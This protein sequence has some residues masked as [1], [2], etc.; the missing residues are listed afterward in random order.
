MKIDNRIEGQTGSP[1][2]LTISGGVVLAGVVFHSISPYWLFLA[3]P[4]LLI[5]LTSESKRNAQ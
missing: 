2:S 4:L 3:V 1:N 5:G